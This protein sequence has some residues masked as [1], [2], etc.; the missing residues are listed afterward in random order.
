[1]LS[2]GA[3]GGSGGGA[4][5]GVKITGPYEAREAFPGSADGQYGFFKR[6]ADGAVMV[7]AWSAE[8]ATWLDIGEMAG[9]EAAANDVMEVD[10]EEAGA[11]EGGKKW[12]YTCGVTLE[13]K[14]GM[15][16]LQLRFDEAEDP[17][18]V[19]T[20]FCAHN[21]VPLG[22][23]SKARPPAVVSM[24]A[25]TLGARCRGFNGPQPNSLP[26]PLLPLPHCR[27][28]RADPRVRG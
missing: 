11:A 27:Q 8:A 7:C 4:S 15:R 22:A 20:R 24:P 19:A 26:C 1:L 2:G 28:R 6:D 17:M 10:G 13:T 25:P 14:S 5:K 3:G 18:D 23:S 9:D 12:D 16:S 21:A